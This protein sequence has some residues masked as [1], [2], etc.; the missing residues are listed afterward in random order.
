MTDRVRYEPIN[1]FK[2]QPWQ[3]NAWRDKSLIVLLTG[4]AGGGKSRFAAEKMHAFLKHYPGSTGLMVRKVGQTVKNSI[5]SFMEHTVIGRDPLVAHRSSFNRFEYNNGSILYYGG[6]KDREQREAIRSIGRDGSV[7][8]AWMEEANAFSWED[9]NELLARLRGKAS[10]WRQLLLT[11]N[12]DSQYH[13]I[14]Q[15]L[16]LGGEASVYF[17]RARDNPYNPADYETHVLGQLR[18]FMRARLLE[19]QWVQAEGLVYDEFDSSPNGHLIEPFPIPTDWRRFRTIDF[20]FTNPFVC[21]WWAVDHDNRAYLYRELYMTE[22]T[23]ADHAAHINAF[24]QAEVYEAT[25]CDHDAEDRATLEDAGIETRPARKDVQSGLQAVK[26]RLKKRKDNTFGLYIFKGALVEE[27]TS[28]RSQ[29]RPTCTE[30]EIPGYVWERDYTGRKNKKETPVKRDD[31]GLD[32]L[33]YFCAALARGSMVEI[34]DMSQ[35]NRYIEE[36][37]HGPSNSTSH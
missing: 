31:H 8:I 19:G 32:A 1:V 10:A 25:W 30:Q 37:A 15:R 12:P 16:I 21:Q 22:R 5:V 24:S 33:R 18:G 7:D 6:M 26:E 20:G 28:L 17:S 3:E 29:Y 13:W 23:V 14:N 36:A 35:L 27:D 34:F 4:G 9:F 11:T 2:P